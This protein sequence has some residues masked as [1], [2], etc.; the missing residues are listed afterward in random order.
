M[1][2]G[3]VEGAAVPARHLRG[4]DVVSLA[5]LKRART[6][7]RLR[8][9]RFA[10]RN[11]FG[12]SPGIFTSIGAIPGV[13]N[14]SEHE[15]DLREIGRSGLRQGRLAWPAPRGAATRAKP[16]AGVPAWRGFPAWSSP[17]DQSRGG[18]ALDARRPGRAGLHR[19]RWAAAGGAMGQRGSTVKIPRAAAVT[20]GPDRLVEIGGGRSLYLECVGSGSP[21][22]VLEAGFGAETFSW[23]DVQPEASRSTRTCASDRAGA[24]SGAAPP[25]VRDARD[26]IADLRRLRGSCC[27]VASCRHLSPLLAQ[28]G[29]RSLARS[30]RRARTGWAGHARAIRLRDMTELETSR[31]YCSPRLRSRPRTSGS[32]MAKPRWPAQTGARHG[33]SSNR[34]SRRARRSSRWRA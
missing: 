15:C 13:G 32:E 18:D 20:Y 28:T 8:T 7:R 11:P 22:V 31:G 5:P 2:S 23:R 4:A 14:R 26:E 3:C 30:A 19:S 17:V 9:P 10:T 1:W 27:A 21:T 33:R 16:A 12:P 29:R 25:G 24:G 6:S 34:N